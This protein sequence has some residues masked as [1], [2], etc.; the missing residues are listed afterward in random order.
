MVVGSGRGKVVEGA[1]GGSKLVVKVVRVVLGGEGMM[2]VLRRR[3]DCAV[4]LALGAAYS[5]S[6]GQILVVVVLMLTCGVV[7]RRATANA[8]LQIRR[9]GA[10]V[11]EMGGRGRGALLLLLSL[12]R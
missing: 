2:V 10:G 9:I 8:I 4:A 5:S 12:W 6:V 7:E 1:G 11:V 3:Q